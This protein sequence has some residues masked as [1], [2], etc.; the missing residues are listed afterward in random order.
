MR[1]GIMP[2]YRSPAVADPGWVREF[3]LAVE[4]AEVES[5]W[6]AEHVVI[7]ATYDSA[8]PYDESG[9][10]PLRYSDPVPDPL[11][12]MAFGAGVTTRLKFGTAVLILPEHNPV[13]LAKRVATIDALSAGR[14]LLGIGVGWLEEEFAAIGVPFA[15]RGARAD[16][17]IAA[18]RALWTGEAVT[19]SGRFA[20]FADVGSNP[21]PANGTV[22]IVVG[23]HTA[24]AARRAGRLGDGFYPLGV[25]TG[26]LPPLLALMRDAATTAG[27]DP[28]AVEITAP[29]PRDAEGLKALAD[30]GVT[31][32]IMNARPDATPDE[33]AQSVGRYRDRVLQN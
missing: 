26:D 3:C 14:V 5:V 12:W 29:S 31:R 10:M 18:L 23:G 4:A 13:H 24:P 16:D 30:L 17:Y 19:H 28:D 1:L 27:R 20:R 2:P 8:Y 7:P 25:D 15:E 11:E 22:P 21:R 32:V 6:L 9:R 33:V